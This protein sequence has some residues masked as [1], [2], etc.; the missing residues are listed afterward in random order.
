MS[1][2]QRVLLELDRVG[3]I[4]KPAVQQAGF[5]VL[6]SPDIPS[7]LIETAYISNPGEERR[8][9]DRRHQEKLASAIH[10][11]LKSYFYAN[12]PPGSRVATLVAQREGDSG[13]AV[14]AQEGPVNFEAR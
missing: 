9:K 10:G 5:L 13:R 11:G 3:E 14:L 2:A 1:A 6:K 12:P 8:L 7:M 4:R